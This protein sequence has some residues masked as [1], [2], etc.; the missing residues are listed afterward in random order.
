MRKLGTIGEQMGG[1]SGGVPYGAISHSHRASAHAGDEVQIFEDSLLI[2]RHAL[3]PRR[4]Q[5]RIDPAHRKAWQRSRIVIDDSAVAVRGA[6]EFRV[7]AV[8]GNA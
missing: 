1:G 6:G 7:M 5:S 2:A 8:K 3:L 4:G